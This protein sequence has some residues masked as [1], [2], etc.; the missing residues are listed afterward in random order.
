VVATGVVVTL[1]IALPQ[2]VALIVGLWLAALLS[3]FVVLW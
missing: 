1:A 2:L 3:L